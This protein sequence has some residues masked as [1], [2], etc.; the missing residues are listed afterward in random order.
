MTGFKICCVQMEDSITNFG[1]ECCHRET[2][3]SAIVRLME[4]SGFSMALGSLVTHE[5]R[6]TPTSVNSSILVWQLC[7]IVLLKSMIRIE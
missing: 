6:E 3:K 7:K 4:E 2:H 1:N 5:Y